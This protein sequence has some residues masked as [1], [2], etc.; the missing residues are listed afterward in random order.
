MKWVS[1]IP[2]VS[3]RLV[4]R[5]AQF[6]TEPVYLSG[7]TGSGKSAIARWIHQNSPR[8]AKPLILFSAGESLAARALEAEEG[9]LVIQ[10]LGNFSPSERTELARFIR[11]RAVVD[12]SESGGVRKM[13][14]ARVIATGVEPIGEFSPFDPVFKDFRI[15]LPGL[16]ERGAELDDI[17]DNLLGEMAHE[18]KR[19]HVRTISSEARAALRAH[20]WRANFRELRNILRYGILRTRGASVE[21]AHL[22]D[23]KDP[24]GILLESREGFRA[25]EERLIR[26][27]ALG[28]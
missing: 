11:T 23:L 2:A 15:H 19:D 1:F 18:L 9:T 27:A 25:T 14:R 26:E 7:E 6:D 12:G 5:A 21:A 22:P 17:I 28:K 3:R 16:G 13:V 20:P 8:G 10:E 24:Q 4:V